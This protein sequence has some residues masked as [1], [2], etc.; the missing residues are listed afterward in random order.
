MNSGKWTKRDVHFLKSLYGSSANHLYFFIHST[1]R[2]PEIKNKK[3]KKQNP[4]K[5]TKPKPKYSGQDYRYEMI[6]QYC[7][8]NL[9]KT[10]TATRLHLRVTIQYTYLGDDGKFA[11][12]K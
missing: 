11:K 3:K 1:Y 2:W 4:R 10:T 9:K 6:Q 8:I 12:I 5:K 7:G